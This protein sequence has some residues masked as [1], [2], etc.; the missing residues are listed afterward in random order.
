LFSFIDS[1]VQKSLGSLATYCSIFSFSGESKELD[2]ETLVSKFTIDIIA[3][4]AFG[5]DS[6]AFGLNSLFEER[7]KTLV[8]PFSG[9]RMFQFAVTIGVPRLSKYLGIETGFFDPKSDEY[10][11]TLIRDSIKYRE[12]NG[13]RG[14]DFLQLILEARDGQLKNEDH[15]ELNEFE[16]DAI[17]TN[18]E[19]K[20]K[21]D[22]D[23]IIAQLILF[24]IGG[25]DSTKTV[26]LFTLY[27]LALNPDVQEKLAREITNVPVDY[28]GNISYESV[29]KMEYM[30]QVICGKYLL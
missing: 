16:K 19:G 10:F 29:N 17:L 15:S 5:I 18:V 30:D 20:L 24:F 4:A 12:P 9:I 28:D 2:V 3:E 23:T 13:V 8:P 26:I 14:N 25:F 27:E 11:S 22:E 6:K 1:T 7:S 21:F